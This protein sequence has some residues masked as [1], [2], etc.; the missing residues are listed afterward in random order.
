MMR[1]Q[2]KNLPFPQYGLEIPGYVQFGLFRLGYCE[3]YYTHAP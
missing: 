3:T 2:H 1:K